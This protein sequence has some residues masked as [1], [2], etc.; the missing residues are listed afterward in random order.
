V[1][2]PIPLQFLTPGQLATV[3]EVIGA[4]EQVVR[5]EELGLRSGR[6]V[7]ML[8]SGSPCIVRLDGHKLCFRESDLCSILV[9]PTGEL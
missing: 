3:T 2:D 4:P 9:Q 1:Y 7:E 8:Q 6:T 5:L